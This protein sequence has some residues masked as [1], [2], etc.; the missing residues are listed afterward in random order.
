M[1]CS[2]G[3]SSTSIYLRLGIENHELLEVSHSLFFHVF[4]VSVLI[5]KHLLVFTVLPLFCLSCFRNQPSLVNVFWAIPL[6]GS[7]GCIGFY[8]F[9]KVS[10]CFI[11]GNLCVC[12]Q[13]SLCWSLGVFHSL[14]VLQEW[15][16][17]RQ[18]GRCVVD[19][20]IY[21]ICP[22]LTHITLLTVCYLRACG[23]DHSY[24][25]V[26]TVLSLF[27]SAVALWGNVQEKVFNITLPQLVLLGSRLV[28][29]FLKISSVR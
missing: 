28:D 9:V 11:D 27:L 8:F 19:S 1:S 7:V 26:A 17:S 5:F 21:G 2:F 18:S 15:G 20:R 16:T 3:V 6:F 13:Y 4:C 14:W 23:S 12:A 22:V 25:V 10:S 29:C 24:S